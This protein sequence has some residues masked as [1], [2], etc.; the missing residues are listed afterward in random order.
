MGGGWG[1]T[2]KAE[3]GYLANETETVDAITAILTDY[4]SHYYYSVTPR[5]LLF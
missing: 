4:R 2:V 5:Q 3:L 1:V